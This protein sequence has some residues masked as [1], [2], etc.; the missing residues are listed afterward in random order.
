MFFI[1]G[2]NHG[3]WD[4]G[5]PQEGAPYYQIPTFDLRGVRNFHTEVYHRC[6]GYWRHECLSDGEF[7]EAVKAFE[8]TATRRRR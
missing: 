4:G 1:G 8:A 7:R 5:I 6:D 2:T 3:R